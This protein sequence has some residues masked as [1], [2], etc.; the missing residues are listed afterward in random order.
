[1]AVQAD[2][3]LSSSHGQKE[4]TTTLGKIMPER[5]LKTRQKDPPQQRIVLTEEEQ[6]EIPF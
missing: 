2:S 1:M 4:F 6:V 3:E 5:E